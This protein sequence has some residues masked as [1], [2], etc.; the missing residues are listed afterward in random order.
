[1][2][3]W[4]F[5]T[6]EDRERE[7][8]EIFDQIG[9]TILICVAGGFWSAIHLTLFAGYQANGILGAVAGL[10]IG[11]ITAPVGALLFSFARMAIVGFIRLFIPNN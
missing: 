7:I 9:W 3:R 11:L 6:E 5:M 10:G 2:R 8:I 1:M 4:F